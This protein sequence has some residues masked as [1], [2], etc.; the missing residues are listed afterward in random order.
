MELTIANSILRKKC[1]WF[2]FK[3]KIKV[4]MSR[5]ISFHIVKL[6]FSLIN[7]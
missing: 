5:L 2:F 6:K 3:K 4:Y 1:N 7:F